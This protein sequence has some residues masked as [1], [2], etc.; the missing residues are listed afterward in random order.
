[1]FKRTNATAQKATT[2]C[3]VNF[4][5][6]H[7]CEPVQRRNKFKIEYISAFRLQQDASFRAL[8]VVNVLAT[9]NAVAQKDWAAITVRL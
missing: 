5:S 8:M 3:T 1:M 4:V 7:F 9:I 6:V 2:D